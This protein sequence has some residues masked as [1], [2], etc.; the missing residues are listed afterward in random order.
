M[1]NN[2]HLDLSDRTTIETELGKG[3]NFKRIAFVLDD[4]PS[5]IS[6]E[7]RSHLTIENVGGFR[8]K[9]NACIHRFKCQKSRIC[10]CHHVKVGAWSFLLFIRHSHISSSL[11]RA[12]HNPI[13]PSVL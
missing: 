3:S 8:M 5:T 2:K 12:I 6:K 4:D 7:M 1:P 13:V 9:Y 10:F 11:L